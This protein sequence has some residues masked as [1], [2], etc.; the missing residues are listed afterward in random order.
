[1]LSDVCPVI[2]RGGP[3]ST[4]IFDTICEIQNSR[5]LDS[6]I[7]YRFRSLFEESGKLED[8][9]EEKNVYNYSTD[10]GKLG[11]AAIDNMKTAFH[12]LKLVLMPFLGV[13]PEK[14]DEMVEA[15]DKEFEDNKSYHEIGRI[16]G[17]KKENV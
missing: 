9:N 2:H 12:S 11:K 10:D 14:F 3:I 4:K 1:M 13:T 15:C 5:N 17:R 16:Y 7:I 8:I 6:N